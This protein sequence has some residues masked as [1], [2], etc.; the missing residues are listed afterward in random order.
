LRIVQCVRAAPHTLYTW[1]R[2]VSGNVLLH[3]SLW[4]T[5]RT[6]LSLRHCHLQVNVL[7]SW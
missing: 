6:A 7:S 3:R 4:Y 5:R 1:G 2:D